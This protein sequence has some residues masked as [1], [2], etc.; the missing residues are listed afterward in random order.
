MVFGICICIYEQ[1]GWWSLGASVIILGVNRELQGADGSLTLHLRCISSSASA[2]LMLMT[3]M[4]LMSHSTLPS[5]PCNIF[6]GDIHMSQNFIPK[7]T[8]QA[9]A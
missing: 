9:L 5:P 2:V 4:S 7:A 6:G 3:I 1:A 8:R